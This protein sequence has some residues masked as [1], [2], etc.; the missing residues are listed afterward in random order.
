MKLWK[1]ILGAVV[2]AIVVLIIVVVVRI[3]NAG[4]FFT[5]QIALVP[6]QNPSLKASKGTL[7][8]TDGTQHNPTTGD[9]QQYNFQPT[10]GSA[11]PEMATYNGTNWTIPIPSEITANT[12][13]T[14][15]RNGGGGVSNNYT[16][17]S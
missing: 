1:W 2:L 3:K 11:I 5:F 15:A 16:M 6:N 9:T 12:V 7:T 17:Q 4:P 13:F 10:S 14:L 8:F